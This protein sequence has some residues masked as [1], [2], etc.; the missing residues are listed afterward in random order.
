MVGDVGA[1]RKCEQ[2][3]MN[4]REMK[5]LR[6]LQGKTI[7]DHI[8]S[9]V[10]WKKAHIKSTRWVPVEGKSSVWLMCMKYTI[11][12]LIII[13]ISL[14]ETLLSYIANTSGM[15]ARAHT[16]LVLKCICICK[17]KCKCGICT[18]TCIW[19]PCGG[20]ICTCICI[21]FIR[22][23]TCTCIWFKCIWLESNAKQMRIKCETNANQMRN[24]CYIMFFY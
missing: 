8:R 24:K 19:L 14:G 5:M 15:H 2:N 20:C 10:I 16:R 4:T 22:I 6:W 3:Q 18:C 7:K 23:C 11:I 9:G 17:C 12:I 13:I 21:W 1:I